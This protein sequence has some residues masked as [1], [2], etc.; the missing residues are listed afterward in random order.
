MKKFF[1]FLPLFLL[2]LACPENCH[3]DDYPKQAKQIWQ[4]DV[5]HAD[6]LLRHN[7]VSIDYLLLEGTKESYIYGANKIAF[8]NGLIYIMDMR[9][10]KVIAY[11]S[12]G[13]NKFCIDKRGQ[14][15]G[16]YLEVKSFAVDEQNVYTID[17]YHHRLYVFDALTGVYKQTLDL[18]FVVWD[19]EVLPD[20]NF[21]FAYAHFKE[22][23]INME[24]PAYRIFITDKGLNI[25]RELF[26]YQEEDYDFLE[27]LTYFTT[28]SKGVVYGTHSWDDL[29]LFT[30]TDSLS[31]I[32][33]EFKNAIPEKY[34]K[35]R[36]VI[37]QNGYSYA[38]TTP[39]LTDNYACFIIPYEGYSYDYV[40]DISRQKLSMNDRVNGYK[41]LCTP[42][43]AHGNKLISYLDS[44]ETYKELVDYGFEN[45][46][47]VAQHLA[48][49]NPVLIIYTMK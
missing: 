42:V 1:P 39:L 17:N 48:E 19:M 23:R 43:A 2:C 35:D 29:Y 27:R 31:R 36:D 13:K 49:E 3:S 10:Y 26:A 30:S 18:P 40:Y 41:G 44:Y 9:S 8:K 33:V 24:Q 38:V 5:K 14:G 16:E 47:A 6:T 4:I 45:N 25:K 12:T 28:T 21:I 34:R 32:K 15:P 22:G 37:M 7:I 11:D 20:G 46:E